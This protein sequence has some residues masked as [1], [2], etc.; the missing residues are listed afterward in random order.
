M[1]VRI[2]LSIALISLLGAGCAT[3]LTADKQLAALMPESSA[4]KVLERQLGAEWTNAP[5]IEQRGNCSSPVFATK[6]Q[7]SLR[8][9]KGITYNPT[10][11]KLFLMTERAKTKFFY[12]CIHSIGFNLDEAAA[13]EV[14][15]A[16]T[17]LGACTDF[18]C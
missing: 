5:Y 18:S 6:V 8:D 1:M 2:F 10:L 17:A 11:G 15:T 13:T 16:L 3:Q 4:K 7:I 9:I 14:T 12:T